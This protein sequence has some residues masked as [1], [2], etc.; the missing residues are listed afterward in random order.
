MV[1]FVSGIALVAVA[2]GAI[3]LLP[4]VALRVLACVVA[5]LAAREYLEIVDSENLEPISSAA[6]DSRI[7]VAAFFGQTRLIDNLPLS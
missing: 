5:A 2:L 1:R 7:A 6:A 4:V 3:L